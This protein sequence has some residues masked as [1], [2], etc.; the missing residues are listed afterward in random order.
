LP[1]RLFRSLIVLA[2]RLFFWGDE[3]LFDLKLEELKAVKNK[4]G[5]HLATPIN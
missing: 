1:P 5:T 2:L 3:N 4:V